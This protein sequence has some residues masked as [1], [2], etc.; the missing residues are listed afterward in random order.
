MN[1][2]QLIGSSK[3]PLNGSLWG[4]SRPSAADISQ[5]SVQR[6]K[7]VERRHQVCQHLSMNGQSKIK[8]SVLRQIGWDDWDPIGLRDDADWRKNGAD[9][10]DG[11]LLHVVSLLS[12][13]QSEEVAVAYL[14][15][16]ASERMGGG[17]Q[18]AAGHAASITTVRAIAGYLHTLPVGP[19][20]VR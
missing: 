19:T 14:D 17:P 5:G 15:W 11:Y 20:N 1:V 9:E 2:R 3:W 16:V 13:G 6:L 18:T 4:D 8:L 12:S 10:Y 7:L